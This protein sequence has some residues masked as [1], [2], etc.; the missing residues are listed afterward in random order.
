MESG[1]TTLPENW[2]SAKLGEVCSKP[3]YGW[4]TKAAPV[5]KNL[6]LLRTSDISGGRVNWQTVPTCVIEPPA[7]EK[8]HLKA[9]DIVVSRAG[10]VGK[11]FLI[12]EDVTDAVFASYLV[13]F[14]P[15]ISSDYI[16]YFMQSRLYWSQIEDQ[17]A[18]IAIPNVNATKLAGLKL[19]IAPLQEQHRIVEKI[20]T[21]FARLDKGEEALRDVQKLLKQ[22]RQ[23]FLKA[24]VTG[25]LTADWRAEREGELEDGKD[26]L[27]RILKTRREQWQG[28]GNYKE[29]AEPDTTDLPELPKGWVWAKL[30]QLF[31]IFGGATPS[32]QETNYWNGSIPWVSSGEVAFCRIKDTAEKVTEEGYSSCSTKL[33]PI[34]TV[35]VAMIGE[36]KTRGQVAILDIEACNNQNSAAIRVSETEVPSEF[37]YFNLLANYESNR[38]K[39]QGG[40]QPALNGAKIKDL[41]IPVCSPKEMQRIVD[42][43]EKELENIDYVSVTLEAEFLRASSLRQSILKEAFAG[44]LVEQ[45]PNDESAAELLKRIRVEKADKPKAKRKSKMKV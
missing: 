1:P 7:P 28:R 20:D 3:Q 19:A 9:G 17:S 14:T 8:Y 43:C 22:Y 32:R 23:S 6:K 12:K 41:T 30:G 33:H 42:I 10:S 13:R 29:P 25:E 39:G 24:A 16:H 18:G 21:L 35:L 4:T 40:N 11:S 5:G 44:R 37:V 31:R 34:G 27:E 26:L 38:S 45:D 2:A 36:G 15:E